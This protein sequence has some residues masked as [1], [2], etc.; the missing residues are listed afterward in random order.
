MDK[1]CQLLLLSLAAAVVA[2]QG[3]HE[4]HN[5]EQHRSTFDVN[6][7]QFEC[8]HGVNECYGNKIQACA[9]K[10]IDGGNN[11]PDFGFNKVSLGFINCLMDKADKNASNYLA[12]FGSMTDAVQNPLKSVPTIVFNNQFKQADTDMAQT[13]FVNALCQYIH[14]DQPAECTRNGAY[15]PQVGLGLLLL[16][17]V[18]R[19][20]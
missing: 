3:Q 8:H 11:T 16:A 15:S 7:Y 10:L 13:N 20:C 14:G 2:V 6:Q 18:L 1:R 4:N 12:M 19:F 17:A 5:H 9:L